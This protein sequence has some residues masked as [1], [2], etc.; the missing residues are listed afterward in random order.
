MDRVSLGESGVSLPRMG[1]GSYQATSTWGAKDEDVA[2][3]IR[4]SCELGVNFVDTAEEYGHGHSEEVVGKAVRE[5]GRDNVVIATKVNGAHLRYEELQKAC[6]A[7]LRRLGVSEIDLYQVHW[8][9]PWEQIPLKQTMK[10]LEKL[11]G[12]GKIRAI[13]VSNFAVRDL[14]EARAI[15]PRSEIVSNQ[16]RYNLVQRD[17]E[18]EVVPY[19]NKSGIEILAWGPLGQGALTGRY[20]PGHL[21][22]NDARRSNPLFGARNIAQVGGV[23]SVLQ[24]IGRRKGKTA[25]QVALNWVVGR[26]AVP[27]AGAST[28]QQAEENA[29]ALGWELDGEDLGAITKAMAGVKLDYFDV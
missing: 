7:S 12:E 24:E 14:E 18:D 23:V 1:V 20:A 25:A 22:G 3:A 4:R 29:G 19:C 27:I 13:G 26:G 9:D 16:V 6:A 11:Q 5:V 17:I 21:P 10:A 15:L 2:T 8:P 28:P